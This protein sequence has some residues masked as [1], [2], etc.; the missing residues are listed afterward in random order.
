MRLRQTE[1]KGYDTKAMERE[2]EQLV[3]HYRNKGKSEE[4]AK[5]IAKFF[6]EYYSHHFRIY[7]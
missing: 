6:I 7:V 1:F 5:E 3:E 2:F 4:E